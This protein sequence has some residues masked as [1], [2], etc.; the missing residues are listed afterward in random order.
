MEM[1]HGHDLCQFRSLGWPHS[2]LP[3]TSDHQK[4]RGL[5]SGALGC[6]PSLGMEDRV[7]SWDAGFSAKVQGVQTKG[8]SWSLPAHLS[9]LVRPA[10]KTTESRG[11]RLGGTGDAVSTF[12]CPTPQEGQT[13]HMEKTLPGGRLVTEKIIFS[14]NPQDVL[15]WLPP[16]F[17]FF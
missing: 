2:L 8:T 12:L 9:P 11:D 5:V 14:Q 3:K 10:T 16:F 4:S 7:V 17:Y 15:A 1:P 6:S 13:G